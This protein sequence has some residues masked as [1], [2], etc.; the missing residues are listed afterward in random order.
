MN[1]PV[2]LALGYAGVDQGDFTAA[3][4]AFEKARAAQQADLGATEC[5]LAYLEL[6]QGKATEAVRIYREVAAR[7]PDRL[8]AWTGLGEA[9][10]A[11]SQWGEARTALEVAVKLDPKS[12]RLLAMFNRAKFEVILSRAAGEAAAGQWKAARASL[13]EIQ[14]LK[15]GDSRSELLL[16]QVERDTLVATA[17]LQ[18]ND[19]VAAKDWLRADGFVDEALRLKPD[20]RVASALKQSLLPSVAEARFAAQLGQLEGELKKAQFAEAIESGRRALE[21]KPGDPQAK[22]LVEMARAGE[23]RRLRFEDSLARAALFQRQTKWD[24]ALKA[25]G[26]ALQTSPGDTRALAVRDGI[27]DAES[28]WM[29]RLRREKVELPKK[30][31]NLVEFMRVEGIDFRHDR[32]AEW[33]AKNHIGKSVWHQCPLRKATFFL[34]KNGV[35]LEGRLAGLGESYSWVVDAVVQPNAL[36]KLRL[37]SLDKGS[38]IGA[39]VASL[40]ERPELRKQSRDVLSGVVVERILENTPAAKSELLPAD[41]IT[42]I[43]AVAVRAWEDFTDLI[44]TKVAGTEVTLV[45]RRGTNTLNVV[46]RPEPPPSNAEDD[47]YVVVGQIKGAN[48]KS[49]TR[50]GSSRLFKEDVIVLEN[51]TLMRQ[52]DLR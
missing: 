51:A 31:D 50:P 1:F 11:N 4:A 16:K 48:S 33:I 6:K 42:S 52:Q 30:V 35:R 32:I 43:D 36:E 39:V 40:S 24:D 23:A 12:P 47:F 9:H 49:G 28:D 10:I 18:A 27:F 45:V 44:R 25:V 17:L 3:K 5:G 20:D 34:D 2:W 7:E 14:G 15:A 19:A 21:L 37:Y 29:A 26:E 22:Q 38:R 13:L 46:V 41:I 8:D